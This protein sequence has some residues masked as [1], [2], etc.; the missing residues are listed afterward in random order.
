MEIINAEKRHLS[1]YRKKLI[2]PKSNWPYDITNVLRCLNKHL[3]EAD[4]TVKQ[5]KENCM[6]SDQNFSSRFS[7]YV[8][9]TPRQ[10]ITYHR[11]QAA[12]ML[13]SDRQLKKIQ[14]NRLGFLVGYEKPSSFAMIFK[15]KTGFSPNS[16]R[17][18]KIF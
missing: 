10:Y 7:N 11:V 16:W 18:K 3:F 9:L 1:V 2:S 6:I 5:L 12:K 4:F 13:L 14:V 15:K 17:K 8:G